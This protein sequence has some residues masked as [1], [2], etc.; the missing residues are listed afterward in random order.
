MND[1]KLC[2][3]ND[4]TLTT[5][6]FNIVLE[7]HKKIVEKGK[8]LK[9]FAKELKVIYKSI[10]KG[11]YNV[12]MICELCDMIENFKSKYQDDSS[13]SE[14]SSSK[15]SSSKSCNSKENKKTEKTDDEKEEIND[16]IADFLK[17]SSDEETNNEK[18]KE[19]NKEEEPTKVINEKETDENKDKKTDKYYLPFINKTCNVNNRIVKTN[20]NINTRIENYCIKTYQY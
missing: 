6:D 15:S 3:E 20:F 8:I 18:E 1:S 2:E 13:D 11:E 10:K 17:D 12:D 5:D 9:S 16:A 4:N 7:N 14:S 19:N